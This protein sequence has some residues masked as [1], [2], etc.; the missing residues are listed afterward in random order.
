MRRLKYMATAGIMA[1]MVAT[2]SLPVHLVYAA[3]T[4]IQQVEENQLPEGDYVV[5]I[6][7]EGNIPLPPV[8]TAFA[9]AFG[10]TGILHVDEDGNKTLTVN[11]SQMQTS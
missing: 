5:P 9:K 11:N 6:S 3:D 8:A 4:S 7:L 10:E 1:A 2:T